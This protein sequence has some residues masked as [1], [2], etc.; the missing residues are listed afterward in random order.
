MGH[1]SSI[2]D[3][4]FSPDGKQALSGSDDGYILVWNLSSGEIVR[5]YTGHTAS[6][7]AVA[8]SPDGHAAISASNDKTLMLWRIDSRNEL[9]QWILAHRYQPQLTCDQ[10]QQYKLTQSCS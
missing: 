3:V 9:V 6:V 4:T 10:I 7:R 5:R 1:T 2:W 8:F